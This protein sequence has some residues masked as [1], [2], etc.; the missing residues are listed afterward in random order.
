MVYRDSASA[1]IVSVLMKDLIG[2]LKENFIQ[3]KRQHIFEQFYGVPFFDLEPDKRIKFARI[4]LYEQ[5]EAVDLFVNDQRANLSDQAY[6]IDISVVRAYIHDDHTRGEFPLMALKDAI[7][8]W[9]KQVD[10]S[11]LTNGY[12]Y[13][14]GYTGTD[15]LERN[16]R[17]VSR[18]LLFTARRDLYKPQIKTQ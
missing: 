18:S 14:F 15:I 12:I 10:A 2:Y 7:V 9:S 11:L 13:T 8:D 5:P 4:A 17:L 6:N 16:E 3:S 1:D